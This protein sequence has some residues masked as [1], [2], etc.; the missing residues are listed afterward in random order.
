[1]KAATEM[2]ILTSQLSSHCCLAVTS[3][4]YTVPLNPT[5]QYFFATQSIASAV[6]LGIRQRK[7]HNQNLMVTSCYDAQH[8]WKGNGLT[9]ELPV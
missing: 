9:A 1:M 4:G 8:I 3:A 7:K 5:Q 6:M 2:A